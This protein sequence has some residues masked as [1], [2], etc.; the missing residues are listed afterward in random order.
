MKLL[1]TTAISIISAL[2]LLSSCS[3]ET[4]KGNGNVI[5]SEIPIS[6]YT[7]IL[8]EGNVDIEYEYKPGQPPYLRLELDENLVPLLKIKTDNGRLS[9]SSDKNIEPTVIKVYTSSSSLEEVVSKGVGNILLKGNVAG[10]KLKIDVNGKSD[11]TAED[12][13]FND[14]TVNISGQSHMQL[15]G[16]NINTTF[17]VKGDANV[18][19]YELISQKVN[20]NITGKG[21]MEI[22]ASQELDINIKG[23]GEVTYTG[24]PPVVKQDIKGNGKVAVRE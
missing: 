8:S 14:F 7:K 13:K 12:L 24:N 4:V 16:L 21:N 9:F 18:S 5:T 19:A 1:L 17:D 10:N 15:K 11:I 20:C 23:K 2:L 3:K 22:F 6:D